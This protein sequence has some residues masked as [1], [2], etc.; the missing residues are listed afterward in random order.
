MG[1]D[2]TI[3]V[4]KQTPEGK[5]RELQ[6]FSKDTNDNFKAVSFFEGR[7]YE[8]FEILEGKYEGFY[9]SN[10]NLLTLSDDLKNLIN[11]EK[12]EYNFNFYE[13]N[14]A[15]LKIYALQ[16]PTVIDLEADFINDLPQKK[17]NPIIP[18]IDRLE[19]YISFTDT[20]FG[21]NLTYSDIKIIYWFNN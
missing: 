4:L 18:F 6:L 12:E 1:K 3:H 14:L 7:S 11:S 19:T 20:D 17:I 21:W 10:I 13:A 16:H 2:I 8:L 9:P 15:D 5:W